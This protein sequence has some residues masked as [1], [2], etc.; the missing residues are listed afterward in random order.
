[1]TSFY[2]IRHAHA[3]FSSDE[4][5][6]LS[7]SGQ[8]MAQEAANLLDAYP[9]TCIY[10]S[11]ARRALQTV[12]PLSG[13][14]GLPVHIE[15]ALRERDMGA[16]EPEVD[17]FSAVQQT[18]QDPSHAFPGGESNTV[19]QLRGIAVIKRLTERHL[20]EHLAISTH[21]NLMTLMMNYYDA[22]CDYDFW[23]ALTMPDIYLLCLKQQHVKIT[24][25]W[26]D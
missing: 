12:A 14:L 11:P 8:E 6:P 9:V 17:F 1:M 13:R 21:G 16:V 25:I 4:Q 3:E 22:R 26:Q 5:R 20:G 7:A 24:R 2:L 19:A 23:K 18:W 15:H 10:S